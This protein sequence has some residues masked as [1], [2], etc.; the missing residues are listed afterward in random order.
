MS[1][2]TIL[3]IEYVN[4]GLAGT[5][6]RTKV[7]HGRT[8]VLHPGSPLGHDLA[9]LLFGHVGHVGGL[10]LVNQ[11]VLRHL[12]TFHLAIEPSRAYPEPPRRLPGP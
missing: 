6:R 7:G 5:E 9:L 1:A 4:L 11:Y 3:G 2:D 12:R 10:T 8:H